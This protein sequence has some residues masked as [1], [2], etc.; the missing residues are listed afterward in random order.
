MRSLRAL[1][2][3]HAIQAAH[4][5]CAICAGFKRFKQDRSKNRVGS[6]QLEAPFSDSC[7]IYLQRPKKG[8]RRY[9]AA[10][11]RESATPK[12]PDRKRTWPNVQEAGNTK[13]PARERRE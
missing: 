13:S 9:H 4:E 11:V 1:Q 8:L 5:I 10:T 2:W 12:E 6:V 7:R 3:M